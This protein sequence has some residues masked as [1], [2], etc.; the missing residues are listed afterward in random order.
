M[1]TSVTRIS[2]FIKTDKYNSSY[3]V[4][5]Y[6]TSHTHRKSLQKFTKKY[7]IHDE[8]SV[9]RI[10]LPHILEQKDRITFRSY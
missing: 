9:I 6:K 10:G 8:S 5:T 2:K 3:R 7:N 1:I 4:A